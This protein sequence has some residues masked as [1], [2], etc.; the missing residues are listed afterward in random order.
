MYMVGVVSCILIKH[1]YISFQ[2]GLKPDGFFVL[3]E[4]IAK[5]GEFPVSNGLSE[6]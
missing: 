6:A 1:T 3:K 5:N 2:V 4:N